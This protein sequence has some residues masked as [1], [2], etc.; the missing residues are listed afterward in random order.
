MINYGFRLKKERQN[1]CLLHPPRIEWKWVQFF[2]KAIL[3]KDAPEKLRA[4]C[5]VKKDDWRKFTTTA[6]N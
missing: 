5:K 6:A 3:V 1:S 2:L 4:S